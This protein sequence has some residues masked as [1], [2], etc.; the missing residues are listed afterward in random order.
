MVTIHNFKMTH[1]GL[2]PGSQDLTGPC[3]V[4]K[5]GHKER[6]PFWVVFLG[7]PESRVHTKDLLLSSWWHL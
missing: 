7:L 5:N 6:E 2:G 1:W 3:G 4:G